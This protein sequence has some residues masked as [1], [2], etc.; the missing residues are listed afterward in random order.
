M[1]SAQAAQPGARPP[2]QQ[3]VGEIRGKVLDAEGKAAIGSASVA[4]YSKANQLVAGALTRQDGTFRI[5]GLAPGAY[6]VKVTMIGYDAHTSADLLIAP[7]APRAQTGDIAL[8][9]SPIK[10]T[11]VEV[12]AERAVVIAPDRNTY[13]ARDIAPAASNATA[14][15][16][17]T[18][19]VSVDADGK[20]S[21]RGNENVVVQINGRPTPMRGAALAGYLKQ[22]PAATIDRI[23][24]VPNPSAKYDPDGMAGILNIVMKQGVDLGRSFGLNLSGS[25]NNMYNGSA[26]FG[27]QAG[28]VSALLTYGYNSMAQQIAGVNDRTRLGAQ[29]VP[30]AYT[31]QDIDGTA[32]NQG[33]NVNSTLDYRLSKTNVLYTSLLANRRT[34][35][36]ESLTGYDELGRDRNVLAQYD[37]SR[38]QNNRNWMVDGALGLRHVV[39]PLKNELTTEVRFMRQDDDENNALARMLGT[40]TQ[41]F[42]LQSDALDAL[43][44]S[45]VGQLDYT[46]AFGKSSKLETG[47]KGNARWMNRDF[48]VRKDALGDG[49]WIDSDLSNAIEL[50]ETINAAYAVLSQAR[51]KLEL[52]AGLRAEYATRDFSLDGVNY[53]HD[54]ASLFPSALA[55]YKLNDK[56]QAKLSYSRRV[57]RPGTQELNPFPSFFDVNN[58]FMGNPE[59]DPEYT[60]A[61][62]A[63]YQRSGRYGSLQLAPFYRYTTNIIGVDIN[64]ADTLANR[65]VTTI[66][67]RNLAHRASWGTDLNGTFRLGKFQALTGFNV[68]KIVT[69]GGSESALSNEGVTWMARI[70]GTYN[71]SPNTMVQA[72]YN[73]RAP[74]VIE[75]GKFNAQHGANF[76]ARQ[77]INNQT[78]VMLRVNDPFKT[79]RFR[80]NVGDDNVLQFT[81]R[82]FNSRGV[83]LSLQY[84]VGQTP[85]IKQRT[86]EVQQGGSPFVR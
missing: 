39:T 7:N 65:E 9:R 13:R 68:F 16:E 1:V 51:G 38:E 61:I 3:A 63:G 32:A 25:T 18:P 80:V 29:R 35:D 56:S 83:F 57:R 58:V 59:L 14:I 42:E 53:P 77:K 26:N 4:V 66:S 21:L 2:A 69:D 49:N 30:L 6:L 46:R 24:V 36:D 85:R 72:M 52:Q 62:E 10:L 70:N 34:V 75:R 5:E 33:H 81:E 73:Y 31:E 47:I 79:M 44:N 55:S 23:E 45:L 40:S 60:H 86:E 74:M 84:N 71:F 12:N 27:Y 11:G 43:T 78:S 15:L 67:F 50:D 54:Y 22:L 20:V 48:Q 37:R 17:A 19:S 64:T 76:A 28:S 41:P 8:A 82:H